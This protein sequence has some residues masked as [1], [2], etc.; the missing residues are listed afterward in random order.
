MLAPA[1][2]AV[3]VGMAMVAPSASA[4]LASVESGE[5]NCV[6][7]GCSQTTPWTFGP[8][9]PG[10]G[11]G[12]DP[13][14]DNGHLW[15]RAWNEKQQ[16]RVLNATCL[17]TDTDPTN[18][19]DGSGQYGP[20]PYTPAQPPTG[21]IDA[22]KRVDSQFLHFHPATNVDAGP[23]TLGRQAQGC[24]Q[25]DADIFGVATTTGR[26][27]ASETGANPM[28][29]DGYHF[30]FYPH[31]ENNR[32]LEP[33]D[34][35]GSNTDAILIDNVGS[36]RLCMDAQW[37]NVHD[38]IRVITAGIGRVDLFPVPG[39]RYVTP[40]PPN[41]LD[42]NP[43]DTWVCVGAQL[44]R[45]NF[46]GWGGNPAPVEPVQMNV[47]GVNPRA[48]GPTPNTNGSGVADRCYKGTV[49]GVDSIDVF[50]DSRS[51]N[52]RDGVPGGDDPN[53]QWDEG[54]QSAA[55]KNE[56]GS[57]LSTTWRKRQTSTSVVCHGT[58]SLGSSGNCDITVT[59]TEPVV[60][61]S[62][63]GS[64][65]APTGSVTLQAFG[66]GTFSSCN[67]QPSGVSSTCT[68]TYSPTSLP[69]GV[70][71]HY[72]E[73]P[74]HLAS[75]GQDPVTCGGRVVVQKATLPA[76]DEQDFDFTTGGGLNPGS[77][78]LD[79]DGGSALPSSRTFIDVNPGN[80]SLP[81]GRY[82]V[83]ETLPGDGWWDQ[84]VADPT[85]SDGSAASEID[86][87]EGQT[88]TCT[89]TNI[90]RGT[91]VVEKE[92]VSIHEEAQDFDFATDGGLT[93]GNFTLD[94]DIDATR[95]NVR[96]F[97]RI[98]PDAGT[99]SGG[100][101]SVEETLPGD[102]WWD[103]TDVSCD[104]GGSGQPS[105]GD[106]GMLTATYDVDPGE[107]VTCVFQNTKR[108]SVVVDKR[109]VSIHE[110]AQDFD[111][112][113][114]GG[115]VPVGFQLDDDADGTL[116]N[117]RT[118]DRVRPGGGS[119]P[120]GAYS[121]E[122]TLPADGWWDLTDLTCDDGAS[123]QPSG[124]VFPFSLNTARYRVDP[125]ET[126]TCEFENTKRATLVVQKEILPG[127]TG[128]QSF[129]FA[130]LP[131]GEYSYFDSEFNDWRWQSDLLAGENQTCERL[132]NGTYIV[133][134]SDP[135]PAFK[136][137]D[138]DCTDGASP[139]PTTS[140]PFARRAVFHL[141]PGE[142]VSCTFTN[143]DQRGVII[144]DKQMGS[145]NYPD[146]NDTDFGISTSGFWCNSS[147]YG[148]FF[149]ST[150]M[151][152]D[153]SVTCPL[154]LPGG[155]YT[156]TE[157]D[158][159][160]NFKVSDIT[161]DDG[162][163]ATPSVTDLQD[164]SITF[165]LDPRETIHCTFT[166]D[167][168]RG[169]IL[170]DKRMGSANYP[171]ANNTD[172]GF[173]TSGF[174]CNGSRY[175]SFFS[176]TAMRHDDEVNC[177]Q[178]APNNSYTVTEADHL[179]NFKVSG[180]TCDDGNSATPSVTDLQ[181]RSITFNLDPDETIDCRFTNDDERGRILWDKRMGSANYPDANNTD[182]GFS[183]SGFWCNGS[184]Y[185]SF[186][187]STAMRHDD[188][189]NCEQLAPNNSYTVTEADHLPNFKV[190]GIT[191]DDGNSAT[192]SVTDLQG[193]SITFNLD[194]DETIDCRFTN[195]DERGRVV[196]DKQ[197]QSTNADAFNMDFAFTTSGFSCVNTRYGGLFNATWMRDDDEVNCEQLSPGGNYTVTEGD[198]SPNFRL[199][200]IDCDD[201]NSV[202][203]VDER[204]LTFNLQADETITC[205]FTNVDERAR[206]I[207]RKV[208]HPQSPQ[209]FDFTA[210]GGL[211][212]TNF[213]LDDDG[214]DDNGLSSRQEFT[215][216]EPRSDYSVAETVPAGWDL[217]NA[218]CDDGSAPS[219][220]TLSA[221]ETVTCTFENR[222]RGKI[223]VVKDARPEEGQDF[224]FT[225]GG[226]LSPTNFS[227]DDD[228][229]NG[230]ELSNT[231]EF[232][233]IAPGGGYSIA[234]TDMPGADGWWDLS[235]A[236]CDDGSPVT[237]VSVSPGETITC[238]F[239]NEKRGTIVIEKEAFP[240]EETNFNYT[241]TTPAGGTSLPSPFQLDDDPTDG[242]L[243]KSRTFA[244]M[245]PVNNYRVAETPN[246]DFAIGVVCDDDQSATPSTG[247]S[248][249]NTAIVNVD[250]GETVKCTFVNTGV[251]P[252]PGGGTPWTTSLVPAFR[253]CVAPNS[254]HVGPLNAPSCTPAEL[255]SSQLTTSAIGSGRGQVRLDV[256]STIPV[257]P[258]TPGNDLD[259]R[260]SVDVTDVRRR[261]DGADY[262][263]SVMLAA[264]LR[265][266]DRRNSPL[267]E[268]SGTEADTV[269]LTI[270]VNCSAT[271]S[272]TVGA[273]CLLPG[274]TR[275][276]ALIPGFALEQHRAIIAIQEL[277]IMDAG[278][279]GTL[280]PPQGSCPPSCGSGD[281]QPYLVP[282][283]FTP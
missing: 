154:L 275:I 245:L 232:D 192:P 134:E 269:E 283:V 201:T 235:S 43:V 256:E 258:S 166:N 72:N 78:Q 1:L 236:A 228:G 195:D 8:G 189:V 194:P 255:E 101:Y 45:E 54:G 180:I 164:R 103:L 140:D 125:G 205:S 64:G 251:Y 146:A 198:H 219:D 18:R 56:A 53:G 30:D 67:L 77:F 83:S 149:S 222:K 129:W 278:P 271:P 143:V 212:P 177:E 247:N 207:V 10:T 52:G 223:V 277:A 190:S 80:G 74:K 193:R 61:P 99:L 119:L 246:V 93:P 69:C 158:H 181:G 81:G 213:Q 220:I 209:V 240:D 39:D 35:P 233:E 204:T 34:S 33:P 231:I 132:V 238:T 281:E 32:G 79:T 137:E 139:T 28:W 173:S 142:T 127:D 215:V 267:N 86:V 234:E 124:Q 26:L 121:V 19:F 157:A 90:K 268:G 197:V 97:D 102:G 13:N 6:P 87:Q 96:I 145:A 49:A 274:T 27:D 63:A 106:V 51:I 202:G 229:D 199:S 279:D 117:S 187:S 40:N 237:N 76:S 135:G 107:T 178:L 171:D 89:F 115:L 71:A 272:T 95:D 250:P 155:N 82:S 105:S 114:G 5:V 218:T 239:V 37:F 206:I 109:V 186:F 208:A 160:P 70:T 191:C 112:T 152:H 55:L 214:D 211:S 161:C 75:Q 163:S 225:A 216:L 175:G 136:L 147:R 42:A 241:T 11:Q 38:E 73:S 23:H 65:S 141:D 176:S 230:N 84:Q 110:E 29:P 282:G 122:E 203:D 265:V 2:L 276:N 148:S 22:G 128:D 185:G 116:A 104:D 91:I 41:L 98:R 261:S 94:D 46:G 15:I 168:E 131:C 85:C 188:E 162:N 59:D 170:W 159:L 9:P 169:R 224:S 16:Y 165:N 156:V 183:T 58:P 172:F 264:R 280:T 130:G 254:N 60:V 12:G 248:P 50:A 244:R 179:P 262:T 249:A 123:P 100:R 263:G 4:K 44:F 243:P 92:V 153:D 182:F 68:V 227:L 270:P 66:G 118:F 111:F 14:G 242:G 273:R 120:G 36:N 17:Q 31:G 47:N 7:N 196:W 174:W 259:V 150:A 217:T 260:V 48:V 151:R 126:V 20:I 138:I 266:T 167:D 62:D 24:V 257:P 226:G 253:R 144:W 21:C 3:G 108:G 200:D 88:I 210:G 113:A 25:F 184:R 252:R 221:G 133:T 57:Q